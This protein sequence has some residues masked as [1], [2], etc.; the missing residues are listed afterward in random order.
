MTQ[1][2]LRLLAG[3]SYLIDLDWG[4]QQLVEIST[5]SEIAESG[6]VFQ[7][8]KEQSIQREYYRRNGNLFGQDDYWK[9]QPD[10]PQGTIAKIG[11]SGVMMVEDGLCSYGLKTFD[12]RMRD[13]YADDRI[14]G[15][16]VDLDSGGGEA[17]AGALMNATITDANKPVIVHTRMMAS[18]ALLG[19]LPA[20]EII[21]Q[22]LFSKIGSIGVM[23]SFPKWYFDQEDSRN[24]HIDIYSDLSPR[25]NEEFRAMEQGDFSKVKAMLTKMD[26]GFMARVRKGRKLKGS[27]EYQAETL[28]GAIFPATNAKRRGLVD[29]IGTFNYAIRRMQSAL[30]Y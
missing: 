9:G 19:S 21:A 26:E 23:A 18:A 4:W 10:L 6:E 29:G 16:L 15:I 17:S 24:D 12:Q 28:S 7:D 30:R 20:T 13:M 3:Q 1:K 5:K 11:L 2:L 25:K 27:K 14:A 22:D 8:M